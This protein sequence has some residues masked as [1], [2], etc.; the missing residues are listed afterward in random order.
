MALEHEEIVGVDWFVGESAPS[1]YYNL[2]GGREE[3]LFFAEGIVKLR[4]ASEGQ[5]VIRRLQSQ[6]DHE[7]VGARAIVRQLEQ[8]PPFDAP[9]ELRLFGPDVEQL[10]IMG[11]QVRQMLTEIPQV[12][13]T[14]ASLTD[15][16]PKIGLMVDEEQARLAGLSRTAI[17][18]QLDAALEGVIGG[19]VLESVEQLPVR[20]RLSNSDR[21]DFG[22]IACLDLRPSE[23]SGASSE[24]H[25][26]LDAVARLQ[27][28]PELAAIA[29]RDGQRV[30]VVQA[31]IHAGVLP[32]VVLDQ[33]RDKLAASQFETPPGYRYEFGGESAERD[34]AVQKLAANAGPLLVLMVATLVLSFNSFRLAGLIAAV[35][36]LSV[37][38][39][40]TML[41]L[42]NYPFGFMAIIGVM[43]L[44]GVAIND[45][46][47]VLAA[48]RE[49]REAREGDPSALRD[50]VM[51]STRHVIAT[52]LTTIAGFLPLVLAG[53]GLW[54]PLAVTIAGGVT[55]ATLLALYF[56]P[57][58][59]HLL[60]C[61]A[62]S[63]AWQ[64]SLPAFDLQRHTASLR[65]LCA[66]VK[67]VSVGRRALGADD[68]ETGWP[69]RRQ[70]RSPAL[71]PIAAVAP[72]NGQCCRDGTR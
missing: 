46:I 54:P 58:A 31:F 2:N 13:H 67:S 22:Q 35:G 43:G 72:P 28:T 33:L 27:L 16:L 4:S 20:V 25:V 15:A 65:E 60:M 52:S 45:S 71:D 23:N 39:G 18:Q 14:R 32:S 3:S 10:R 1:F 70:E 9:V 21:A 61:H 8:G 6:L 57:S 30:N 69:Q 44:I 38:L 37:G 19:S 7:L 56:T 66:S 34:E 36:G 17:A 41:W 47:V 68:R 59:Y 62:T 12:N 50:V 63:P 24:H 64:V 26:P 53:G 51:R 55:G 29:R 48:I 49:N 42:F 5:D 40:M 11:E